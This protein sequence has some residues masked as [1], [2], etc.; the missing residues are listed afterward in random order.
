LLRKYVV[1]IVPL[2]QFLKRSAVVPI[3]ESFGI[4]GYNVPNLIATAKILGVLV[5]HINTKRPV[6]LSEGL[7]IIE[8]PHLTSCGV[9]PDGIREPLPNERFKVL[10]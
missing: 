7:V 4:D 2:H 8:I 1:E 9:N 6:I 3:A 10:I 5:S